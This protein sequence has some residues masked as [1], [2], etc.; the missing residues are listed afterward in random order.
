MRRCQRLPELRT[1][2]IPRDEQTYI[3]GCARTSPQISEENTLSVKNER[4]MPGTGVTIKRDK[5]QGTREKVEGKRQKAKGK[6]QK[7][8]SK[9]G[10]PFPLLLCPLSL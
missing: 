8:K 10:A 4:P 6:R 1:P 9:E 2:L 5:G 3:K 7:A